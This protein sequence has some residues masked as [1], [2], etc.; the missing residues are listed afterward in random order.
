[1]AIFTNGDIAY[2][3]SV[4][5]QHNYQTQGGISV[6]PCKQCKWVR[7]IVTDNENRESIIELRE[8]LKEGGTVA[9]LKKGLEDER[10]P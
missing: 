9:D 7:M 6:C 10:Q 5:V 2:L 8:F 3:I 4:Y 1:M